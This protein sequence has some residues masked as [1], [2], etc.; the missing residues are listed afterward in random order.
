MFERQIG[1]CLILLTHVSQKSLVN[2]IN[3]EEKMFIK[4]RKHKRITNKYFFLITDACTEI[5]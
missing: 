4:I 2:I 3:K 1:Q 5:T